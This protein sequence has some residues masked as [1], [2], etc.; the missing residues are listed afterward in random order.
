MTESLAQKWGTLDGRKGDLIARCEQY[1][2]WTDPSICPVENEDGAEQS[3]GNVT[4]GARLVNHLSNKVVDTMFP[5]DRPF[6]AL[7]L[8]PEARARLEE[9]MDCYFRS[10]IRHVRYL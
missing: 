4:I 9:E 2:M 7:A 3:R 10:W 5:S 8:S 1:A 6:F